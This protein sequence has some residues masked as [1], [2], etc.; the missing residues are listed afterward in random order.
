MPKAREA[1]NRHLL[2]DD[3]RQVHLCLSCD[4][5]GTCIANRMFQLAHDISVQLLHFSP[6]YVVWKCFSFRQLRQNDSDHNAE[7]LHEKPNVN[8]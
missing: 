5:R 6:S 1:D 8:S 7:G 4:H 2:K 3:P